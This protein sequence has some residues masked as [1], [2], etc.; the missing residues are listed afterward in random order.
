MIFK[1]VW[2]LLSGIH[3]P[4]F[5][6]SYRFVLEDARTPGYTFFCDCCSRAKA[7]R[8]VQS[9]DAFLIFKPILPHCAI[10]H[11][12]LFIIRDEY[13]EREK[14]RLDIS[15]ALRKPYRWCRTDPSIKQILS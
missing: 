8:T 1:R 10:T 12:I 7:F 9:P 6:V 5:V 4:R 11:E 13:K 2:E 15:M 3:H 14:C